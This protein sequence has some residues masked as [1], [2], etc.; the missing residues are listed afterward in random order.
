MTQAQTD[1]YVEC[2]ECGH[3]VEYDHDTDGCHS[4]GCTCTV[5][6]SRDAKRTLRKAEG[7][8]AT[9]PK[10]GIHSGGAR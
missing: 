10:T 3:T 4:D 6:W 1:R 2:S 9:W 5:R 8:P 7:L